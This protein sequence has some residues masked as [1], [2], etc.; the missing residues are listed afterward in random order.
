MSRA[1]TARAARRRDLLTI[2][3]AVAITG[4][5]LLTVMYRSGALPSLGSSYEVKAALPTA[6]RL[7]PGSRVKT[8]GLDIGRVTSVDEKGDHAI[9]GMELDD[10]R[11]PAPADSTV[12]VRLRTV[13][14]ENYVDLRPGRSSRDLPSGGR[15]G[16]TPSSEYVEV[17]EILSVLDG[18]VR[19]RAR[20]TLRGLARGLEGR[21]GELNRVV[22]GAAGTIEAASAVTKVLERDKRKLARFVERFGDIAQAVGDRGRATRELAAGLRTTATAVAERDGSLRQTLSRLPAALG[23]VRSVSGTLRRVSAASTPVVANLART[24]DDLRPA[25]RDL[26]PGAAELRGV[27]GRLGSAAGPLDNALQSLRTASPSLVRVFSNTRGL[28]CELNPF[29]K[30]VAPYAKDVTAILTNMSSA[31]NY[32]DATGHAARLGVVLSPDSAAIYTPEVD[33][34]VDSLMKTGVMGTLNV[35]GWNPLPAPG[36]AGKPR[37]GEGSTG[38]E[39]NTIP[40]PDIKAAC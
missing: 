17:D 22:G 39:N 2:V 13:V 29:V 8:A 6:V 32:H 7:A 21:G 5:C 27:I 35:R 16:P 34:Q 38:I 26:R 20:D 12:S 28:M 40:H 19:A 24:V 25:V 9:I 1:R 31:S 33:K 11:A 4:G 36:T 30:Y 14:G 15:L 10:D 3:I 18:K 37:G 23:A